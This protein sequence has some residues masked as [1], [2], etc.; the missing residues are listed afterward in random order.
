MDRKDF[1][2]LSDWIPF[3]LSE[4][5]ALVNISF[6]CKT[7][8]LSERRK[9]KNYQNTGRH[10]GDQ[11]YSEASNWLRLSHDEFLSARKIFKLDPVSMAFN[12]NLY[13]FLEVFS[14]VHQFLWLHI[15]NVIW[16]KLVIL[17]LFVFGIDLSE[18]FWK[19]RLQ[20]TPWSYQYQSTTSNSNRVLSRQS[21]PPSVATEP[22][23]TKFSVTIDMWADWCWWGGTPL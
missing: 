15:D 18:K 8:T 4:T 10:W 7:S 23:I 11:Q 2:F 17:I 21:I 20:I 9:E 22:V 1:M 3:W 14:G 5:Q 19:C 12:S 13:C 6:Y 16:K